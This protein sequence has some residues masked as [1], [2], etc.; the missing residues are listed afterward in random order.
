MSTKY[1]VDARLAPVAQRVAAAALDPRQWQWALAEL[2]RVSD[3]VN[4]VMFS[5]DLRSDTSLDLIHSGYDPAMIDSYLSYFGGINVWAEKFPTIAPGEVRTCASLVPDED[6]V[7][8]EFYND[9]L[10]PQEDMRGGAGTVISLGNGRVVAVA[11]SIR[12][13]DRDRIE[14]KFTRD[15]EALVP[16][17]RASLLANRML[18]EL[19]S[20]AC[21]ARLSL[22]GENTALLVVRDDGRLVHANA[23]GQRLVCEGLHFGLDILNRLRFT[24]PEANAALARAL[25]ELRHCEPGLS[26]P[27]FLNGAR[28]ESEPLLM[29]RA[30]HLHGNDITENPLPFLDQSRNYLALLISPMDAEAEATQPAG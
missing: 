29:C 21:M 22:D 30:L 5:H 16:H 19:A 15:L 18:G 14:A 28:R 25:F 26:L 24:A 23:A 11:G 12:H 13:K 6:L 2:Q 9:W 7:Q 10:R 1:P 4:V 8:T 20:L 3:G 17:I 27:F